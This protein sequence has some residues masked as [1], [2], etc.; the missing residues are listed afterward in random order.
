MSRQEPAGQEEGGRLDGRR[1][2]AANALL[3]DERLR[4]RLTDDAYRPLQAWALGWVDAHA[5]ATAGLDDAPA[6]QAIDRGVAGAKAQ[7]RA[8]VGLIERWPDLDRV[9]RVQALAA[10]APTFPAPSLARRVESLASLADADAAA[11]QVAAA[12]PARPGSTDA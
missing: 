12:L 3:E 6:S 5:R 4:G 11:A 8:L 10:V 7:L 9:G 1:E 2:R